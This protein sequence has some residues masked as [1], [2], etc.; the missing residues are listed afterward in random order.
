MPHNAAFHQGRQYLLRFKKY[1]GTEIRYIVEILTVQLYISKILNDVKLIDRI[2][3]IYYF[4]CQQFT[5][6]HYMIQ[7]CLDSA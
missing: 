7:N 5:L 3:H 4:Y 6:Q 1:S 2:L